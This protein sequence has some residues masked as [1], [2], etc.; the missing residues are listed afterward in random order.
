[1]FK[2]KI[3]NST[4]ANDVSIKAYVEQVSVNTTNI[5]KKKSYIIKYYSNYNKNVI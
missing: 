3:Q 4:L 5:A 2:V 1:M